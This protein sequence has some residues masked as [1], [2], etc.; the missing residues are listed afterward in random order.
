MSKSDIN[1]RL[2]RLLK[3]IKLEEDFKNRLNTDEFKA[4]Q[5]V[6]QIEH[7]H[8]LN[9]K[10]TEFYSSHKQNELSKI[11]WP[12]EV[13]DKLKN[14]AWFIIITLVTWGIDKLLDCFFN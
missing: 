1:E 12:D 7:E 8:G 3:S 2:L 5:Q 11:L 14:I 10:R 9:K 6:E 13:K 4:Y